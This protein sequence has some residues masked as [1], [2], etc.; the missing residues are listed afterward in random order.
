M[1]KQNFFVIGNTITVKVRTVVGTILCEGTV[2]TVTKDDICYMNVMVNGV[3]I[4]IWSPIEDIKNMVAEYHK[5]E[6]R[7][8]VEHMEIH[9]IEIEDR[10]ICF[11]GEWSAVDGLRVFR[12]R[13]YSIGGK[14]EDLY[15][16][17]EE[18]VLYF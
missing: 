14:G 3:C 7:Y 15:A 17:T 10:K 8:H 11:C 6:G 5:K 2:E 13:P 16:V 9:T 18:N 4:D 12:S 1:E